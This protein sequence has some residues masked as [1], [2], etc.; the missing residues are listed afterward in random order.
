MI[1]DKDERWTFG[2]ALNVEDP[3][4][5]TFI[6]T[7]QYSKISLWVNDS[8]WVLASIPTPNVTK[9]WKIS[10]V[11]LRYTIRGLGWNDI[12][13]LLDLPPELPP[14]ATGP[15]VIDKIVIRDGDETVHEFEGLHLTKIKDWETLTL[16]LPQSK[17]FKFGLGVS[18][19]VF[20]EGPVGGDDVPAEILFASVGLGFVKE[21]SV[22]LPAR[23]GTPPS[24]P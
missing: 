20:Y 23:P 18:I 2:H 15:G 24:S 8:N 21:T 11:M 14:G 10:S 22:D 7:T 19:H 9:G 6:R 1:I 4:V 3:T 16:A 17:Q 5:G 13:D 12:G